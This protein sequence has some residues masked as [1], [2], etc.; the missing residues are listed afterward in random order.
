MIIKEWLQK[1]I[2]ASVSLLA[3]FGF[4]KYSNRQAAN[5]R[6]DE[7]KR[8]E[9]EDEINQIKEAKEIENKINAISPDDKRERLRNFTKN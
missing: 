9:A 2:A 6:E 4:L 8:D 7:I 5:A 1:F 3:V